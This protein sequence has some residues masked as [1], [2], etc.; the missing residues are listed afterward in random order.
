[1]GDNEVLRQM[2]TVQFQAMSAHSQSIGS[3]DDRRFVLVTIAIGGIA[4]WLIFPLPLFSPSRCWFY[5]SPTSPDPLFGQ[6]DLPIDGE[7][8]ARDGSSGI[9]LTAADADPV[10]PRGDDRIS[11]LRD[12]SQIT[13]LQLKMNLPACT[14][15]EMDA[16]E[17][18]KSDERRPLDRRELKIKLND[19]VSRQPPGVGDRRFSVD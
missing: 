4:W 12:H 18:A 15:L 2:T 13:A 6:G 9:R 19:L 17:A 1:M 16:L 8:P 3:T 10:V 14:R 5:D 11:S 7:L